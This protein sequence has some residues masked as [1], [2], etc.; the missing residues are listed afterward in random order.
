[1]GL[2][3]FQLETLWTQWGAV[4]QAMEGLKI[5]EEEKRKYLDELKKHRSTK[6]INF[7]NSKVS[8]ALSVHFIVWGKR[9]ILFTVEKEGLSSRNTLFF[10]AKIVYKIAYSCKI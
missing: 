7:E 2:I 9:P 10:N 3:Y 8:S 6:Y 5:P 1:V 4:E